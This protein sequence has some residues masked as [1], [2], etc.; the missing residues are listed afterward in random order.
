M[1][2][3][4]F[5]VLGVAYDCTPEEVKAAFRALA[6]LHHPDKG[7]DVSAFAEIVEAYGVLSSSTAMHKHLRELKESLAPDP[8]GYAEEIWS[9]FLQKK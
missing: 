5:Q 2:K 1:K 4:L 8:I 7:G 3:D 6:L 9:S